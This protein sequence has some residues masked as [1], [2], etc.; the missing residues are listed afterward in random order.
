MEL[1]GSFPGSQKPTN[2]HCPTLFLQYP[3][4]YHLL[5]YAYVFQVVSSPQVSR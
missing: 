4:Q 5:N 1:E 2:E 3:F